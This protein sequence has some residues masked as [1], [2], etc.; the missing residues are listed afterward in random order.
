MMLTQ[1]RQRG[2]GTRI[3]RIMEEEH[4]TSCLNAVVVTNRDSARSLAI[5]PRAVLRFQI[6]NLERFTASNY[7]KVA[8]RKGIIFHNHISSLAAA[9][10][11]RLLPEVPYLGPKAIFVK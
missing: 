9:N 6:V 2:A 3:G 11:D 5:D 8:T 4:T 10:G 1:F 7:Q